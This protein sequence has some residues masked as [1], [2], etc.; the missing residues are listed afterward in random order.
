ML[1]FTRYGRILFAAVLALG[2]GWL[3]GCGENGTSPDDNSES[4]NGG[5]TTLVENNT[6]GVDGTAGSC[7]TT[8][9]GGKTWMAENLNREVF[10]SWCYNDSVSYCKKYGRLYDRDAAKEVCPLGWHLPTKQEWEALIEIAGKDG[11]KLKSRSGWN[12]PSRVNGK[13]NNGS[14]DLNF[15][16]LP[17]GRRDP[18]GVFRGSNEDL[19][20][21]QFGVWWSSSRECAACGRTGWSFHV[22]GGNQ[23][24]F[25]DWKDD[26]YGF[27]VRCVLGD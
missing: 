8:V 7:K 20:F 26:D 19:V 25:L 13:N 3:S 16:A 5:G 6:C 17:G 10:N 27:S 4:G 22:D 15:S 9:I 18:A 23:T 12:N 24:G 1:L 11:K 21:G 2:A 14:D